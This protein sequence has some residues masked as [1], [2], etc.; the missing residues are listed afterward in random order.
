M[1]LLSQTP[2]WDCATINSHIVYVYIKKK[3][4]IRR[5][6]A[7]LT[8][9]IERDDKAIAYDSIDLPGY[10]RTATN[11]ATQTYKERWLTCIIPST[12]YGGAPGLH[13]TNWNLFLLT[14]YLSSSGPWGL[15]RPG[16]LFLRSFKTSPHFCFNFVKLFKPL[17]VTAN[18]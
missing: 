6:S 11:T 5:L 13:H 14:T 1:W 17:L 4:M 12:F 8:R 15:L 7:L 16:N 9:I 3:K 10:S 18:N 2:G